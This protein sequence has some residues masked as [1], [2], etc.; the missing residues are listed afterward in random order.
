[1]VEVFYSSLTVSTGTG[2]KLRAAHLS[3]A[4]VRK[5]RHSLADLCAKSL[6]SG[7]VGREVHETF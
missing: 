2:F 1:L 7:E 4:E 6:Y 3:P 5:V